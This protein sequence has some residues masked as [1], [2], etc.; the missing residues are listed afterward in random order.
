MSIHELLTDCREKSIQIGIRKNTLVIKDPNK[1][2]DENLRKQL[3]ENK[4]AILSWLRGLE[5]PASQSI[6]HRP[7]SLKKIPL[8]F[9]QQRLWLIDAISDGS[10]QY[11]VPVALK[12]CGDLSYGVLEL[13]L[14][15]LI[16]NHESW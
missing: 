15:S 10:S 2:L 6:S 14:E 7:E 11:N 9:A 1:Q 4:A 16:S 3:R 13:V 8:S 12:V 5:E